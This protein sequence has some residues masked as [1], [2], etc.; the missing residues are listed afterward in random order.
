MKWIMR[1]CSNAKISNV[2]EVDGG[3]VLSV[4]VVEAEKC[5]SCV[6]DSNGYR[7]SILVAAAVAAAVRVL[8]A[9]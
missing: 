5:R 3:A 6:S 4:A 7:P 9:T 8:P 2:F 1:D